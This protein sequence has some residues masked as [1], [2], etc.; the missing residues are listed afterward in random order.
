LADKDKLWLAK[1]IITRP[2]VRSRANADGVKQSR[3]R[4][5]YS[6]WFVQKSLAKIRFTVKLLAFKFCRDVTTY[7]FGILRRKQWKHGLETA[8]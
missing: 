3:R 2:V 4:A 7:Y 5:V 8:F 1:Q 6:T